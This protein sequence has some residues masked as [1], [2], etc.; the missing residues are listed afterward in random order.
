[1]SP[2]VGLERSPRHLRELLEE[3]AQ[4]LAAV[5]NQLDALVMRPSQAALERIEASEAEGDRIFH[6]L[7]VAVQASRRAGPDRVRFVTL[8]QALEDVLDSVND[9]AWC[10]T[11]RPLTP[12][13]DALLALRD[14]VRAA[15]RAARHADD[16]AGREHRIALSRAT[17]ADARA[18]LRNARRRLLVQ[19]DDPQLAIAGDALL[20]RVELSLAACGRLREQLERQELG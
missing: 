14:T 10:W 13:A 11:R 7:L 19:Q 4:N 20:R 6:D 16:T 18:H 2:T 12:A 5:A 1:M 17:H 9:L 15:A 8:G 3:A